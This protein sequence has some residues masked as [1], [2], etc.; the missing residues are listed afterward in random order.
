MPNRRK[1]LEELLADL[2]TMKRSL[3]NEGMPMLTEEFS[4]YEAAKIFLNRHRNVDENDDRVT[5][6]RRI[7]NQCKDSFNKI[8]RMI[9]LEKGLLGSEQYREKMSLLH[10]K[11]RKLLSTNALTVKG[12]IMTPFIWNTK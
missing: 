9:N 12:R 5:E 11:M 7:M 3:E 6:R 8:K 2:D 4:H 1:T 10:N